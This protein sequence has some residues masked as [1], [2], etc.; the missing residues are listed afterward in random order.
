MPILPLPVLRV[1]PWFK[2]LLLYSQK[3]CF[4]FSQLRVRI[5]SNEWRQKIHYY[6]GKLSAAR[7]GG[8]FQHKY[9]IHLVTELYYGNLTYSTNRKGSELLDFLLRRTENKT[10]DRN[11]KGKQ[12]VYEFGHENVPFAMRIE[13]LET[14]LA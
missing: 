14:F 10:V 11:L 3:H 8:I 4:G 13:P 1:W 6:L 2:P 9:P 5:I 12:R 7:A